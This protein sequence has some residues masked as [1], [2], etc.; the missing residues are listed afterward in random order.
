MCRCRCNTCTCTWALPHAHYLGITSCAGAERDKVM[1]MSVCRCR[2]NTCK[3]AHVCSGRRQ[4]HRHAGRRT[5]GQDGSTSMAGICPPRPWAAQHVTRQRLIYSWEK[6]TWLALPAASGGCGLSC[7]T[8]IE[9]ET[10]S[11][12]KTFTVGAPPWDHTMRK[13]GVASR[14]WMRAKHRSALL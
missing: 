4:L 14:A 7:T 10:S 2:C 5:A 13:G 11:K 3:H 8:P 12:P 6:L 1:R 9:P